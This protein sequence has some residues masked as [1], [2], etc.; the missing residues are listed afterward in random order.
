[1]KINNKEIRMLPI[2][3]RYTNM[4][5]INFKDLNFLNYSDI[6]VARKL[7]NYEGDFS[8]LLELI[9][10]IESNGFL[11]LNDQILI[12]LDKNSHSYYA[13][14][15]NRRLLSIKLIN[16]VFSFKDVCGEKPFYENIKVDD[17]EK[18]KNA[19]IEKLD[20][21]SKIV[22]KNDW[23]LDV[24]NEDKDI[25]WKTIYSKHIG[26]QI[27]K[28]SWSR[29]KYFDDL[30][31]MLKNFKENNNILDPIESLSVLFG[32]KKEIIKQDIRSALWIINSLEIY[33][34]LNP[35]SQIDLRQMEVSGYELLLS[36]SLN[37]N[38]KEKTMRDFLGIDIDIDKLTF[39]YSPNMSE[40]KFGDVI[41]FLV[42]NA[43]NKKITTRGIKEEIYD[44]LSEIIGSSITNKRTLNYTYNSLKEKEKEKKLNEVEDIQFQL[45]KNLKLNELDP[46]QFIDYPY[47][48]KFIKSIKY[49][50]RNDLKT[51]SNLKNFDE[52][53]YPFTNVSLTIRNIIDLL[54]LE[55]FY[56]IDGKT[57]E[58]LVELGCS[59]NDVDKIDN[60]IKI[61][62]NSEEHDVNKISSVLT[63]I[64]NS[65]GSSNLANLIIKLIKEL[66]YN[67]LN[68]IGINL[69][70]AYSVILSLIDYKKQDQKNN[71]F[72]LLNN[73]VH[74]PY[75]GFEKKDDIHM[76]DNLNKMYNAVKEANKLF[77][78]L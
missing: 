78:I 68:K 72:S 33:N 74:K 34:K 44:D 58:L 15:G 40:K 10:S 39:S 49:M 8:D 70:E 6:D 4:E 69:D 1:M 36:Q 65:K 28:R 51:L 24:S 21:M 9:S 17:W 22:L 37:I 52:N 12:H 46:T 75:Y 23:F 7:L 63:N 25:I 14:E 43:N 64:V 31:K 77:K 66:Y 20:G 42:L 73:L 62:D 30:L 56:R 32:K 5:K 55:F 18:N 50:M 35:L 2:N 47:D 38:G 61:Y 53:E 71:N 29:A 26:E 60:F 54:I 48:S 41:S 27:G 57:N 16:K 3:P 19:I 11:Y 59:Q 45:L 13:L 67:Q 76:I